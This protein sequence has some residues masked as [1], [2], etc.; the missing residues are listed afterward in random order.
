M[1]SSNEPVKS[2]DGKVI[3]YSLLID[4]IKSRGPLVEEFEPM[5]DLFFY[6]NKSRLC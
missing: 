4:A 6:P 1:Q 5:D 2:F 3:D